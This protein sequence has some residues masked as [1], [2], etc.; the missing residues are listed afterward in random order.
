MQVYTD[1][2]TNTPKVYSCYVAYTFHKTRK[3]E[4]KINTNSDNKGKASIVH[5]SLI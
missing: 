3:I 1:I 2:I 5:K 4:E